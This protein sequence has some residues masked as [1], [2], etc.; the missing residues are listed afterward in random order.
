[1]KIGYLGWMLVSVVSSLLSLNAGSMEIVLTDN[2]KPF[3]DNSSSHKGLVVTR[4][5]EALDTIPIKDYSIDYISDDNLLMH[6]PLLEK[7][8][9]DIGLRWDTPDCSSKNDTKLC[10]FIVSKPLFKTVSQFYRRKNS[11]GTVSE[12]K[13]IYGKN[14]C[15]PKGWFGFDLEKQGFVDG[16]NITLTS[17]NSVQ[18]CFNKLKNGK[19]DFVAVTE[20]SARPII[21]SMKLSKYIESVDALS[22]PIRLSL[23][24]HKN[25]PK[26]YIYIH[27][28][29]IGLSKLKN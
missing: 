25:N 29:N 18:E 4:V 27:K 6:P 2:I 1:M 21:K 3:V 8:K 9:Y 19:V 14:I 24:A 13:E 26:A 23:I 28:L 15:R 22:T 11:S 7:G 12:P 10:N 16:Q 5:K 20:Y 17:P